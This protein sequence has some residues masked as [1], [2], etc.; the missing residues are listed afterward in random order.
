[1]D[2]TREFSCQELVELVS[3]YLEGALDPEQVARFEEHLSIC[4]GCRTYLDQMRA[5]ISLAGSLTEESLPSPARDR[6]LVAFRDWKRT[7]SM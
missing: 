1:M 3:D 5:T 6:L 4:E 7:R 2:D